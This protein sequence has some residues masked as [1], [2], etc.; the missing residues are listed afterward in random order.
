MHLVSGLFEFY[1]DARAHK[2]QKMYIQRYEKTELF[3]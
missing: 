1:D 3:L 2:L